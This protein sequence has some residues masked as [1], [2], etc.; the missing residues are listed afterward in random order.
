MGIFAVIK[1]SSFPWSY[2]KESLM[3]LEYINSKFSVVKT[4]SLTSFPQTNILLSALVYNLL[5]TLV[6]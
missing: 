4:I 1:K 2:R 6:L 3:K 5:I